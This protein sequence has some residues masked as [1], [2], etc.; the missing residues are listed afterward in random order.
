[1]WGTI[2]VYQM[3]KR[4]FYLKKKTCLELGKE[5]LNSDMVNGHQFYQYQQNERSPLNL[6][7]KKKKKKQ[8]MTYDNGNPGLNQLMV[9]QPSPLDNWISNGNTYINKQL[10]YQFHTIS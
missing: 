4:Y 10:I 1:M 8:I 5:S 2:K 6:T 3:E 7:E 9:T